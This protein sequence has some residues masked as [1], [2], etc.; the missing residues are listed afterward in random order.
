MFFFVQA[1]DGRGIYKDK[2]NVDSYD[3]HKK[4]LILN[5]VGDYEIRITNNFSEYKVLAI[6]MMLMN[7][8]SIPH[9]IEKKDINLFIKKLVSAGQTQVDGLMNMTKAKDNSYYHFLNKLKKISEHMERSVGVECLIFVFLS[10]IQIISMKKLLDD[11][12]II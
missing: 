10:I 9:Q 1:P 11:K 12:Q 7:C 6:S 5:E 8:H 3:V 4:V 2:V